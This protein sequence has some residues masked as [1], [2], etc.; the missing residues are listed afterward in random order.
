MV[1]TI[2]RIEQLA[3]EVKGDKN[4]PVTFVSIVYVPGQ[5]IMLP[6]SV[7]FTFQ[8]PGEVKINNLEYNPQKMFVAHYAQMWLEPTKRTKAVYV[9]PGRIE[10]PDS[11]EFEV[12]PKHIYVS[13]EEGETLEAVLTSTRRDP[14][15]AVL[16]G[17]KY[18]V[19][20]RSPQLA[21][22]DGLP[23]VN[24]DESPIKVSGTV[25][26]TPHNLVGEHSGKISLPVSGAEVS[27]L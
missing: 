4:T 14:A 2:S 11:G 23:V 8:E 18:M 26:I 15:M 7:L 21:V 9:I 22:I 19:E 17:N 25:V 13:S 5:K 3:S 16:R 27:Y 6:Q 24:Y 20:T 1:Q 10:M 12:M